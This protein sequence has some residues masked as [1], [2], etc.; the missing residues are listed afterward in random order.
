MN[1]AAARGMGN[2]SIAAGAA[3]AAAYDAAMPLALADQQQETDVMLKNIDVLNAREAEK[4]AEQ[5]QMT[6]SGY[7]SDQNSAAAEADRLAR[8][9]LQRE[10]LAFEGEQNQLGRVHDTG[11][12]RLGA[13]LQDYRDERLYG[14][15]LGRMGAEYGYDIGRAGYGADL[16]LRN[17]SALASQNYGFNRGLARDQYDYEMRLGLMNNFYRDDPAMRDPE[18]AGQMV[19]WFLGP[20]FRASSSYLGGG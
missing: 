18:V 4:A 9:Q 6:M 14:M 3:R 2:S 1:Q 19:Q 12:M 16:D 13:G 11:T 8:L 15:D 5:M 7:V 10:A 20:Q 17:S